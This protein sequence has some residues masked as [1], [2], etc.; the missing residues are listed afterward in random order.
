MCAKN[1]K[2]VL[3]LG[4][5]YL[6][7]VLKNILRS[8]ALQEDYDHEVI[9]HGK[10]LVAEMLAGSLYLSQEERHRVLPRG[11]ELSDLVHKYAYVVMIWRHPRFVYHTTNV[12]KA[13]VEKL[14]QYLSCLEYIG[15]KNFEPDQ[16]LEVLP[17]LINFFEILESIAINEFMRPAVR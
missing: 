10:I 1:E 3:T 6:S 2:D 17:E 11:G 5:S 16:S 12:P 13:I 4:I 8:Y 9:T 15:Q 7:S 14:K